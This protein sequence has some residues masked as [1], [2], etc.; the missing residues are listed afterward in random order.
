M[1]FK[2]NDLTWK[3]LLE[4]RSCQS[5]WYANLVW[6]LVG[7]V[8]PKHKKVP[9]G[10]TE[11]TRTKK[12]LWDA[13]TFYSLQNGNGLFEHTYPRNSSEHCLVYNVYC[14]TSLNLYLFWGS[15]TLGSMAFKP[16]N[17]IHPWTSNASH[18]PWVGMP[19][20]VPRSPPIQCCPSSH[21]LEPSQSLE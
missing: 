19:K 9:G 2:E 20:F 8:A 5:S 4:F 11:E 12:K 17:I 7:I 6:R 3:K 13:K 14:R 15:C 21:I 10:K 18:F 16:S 1:K